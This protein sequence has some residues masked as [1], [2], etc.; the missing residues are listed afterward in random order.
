MTFID[1]LKNY[2]N[3]TAIPACRYG[4]A[5]GVETGKKWLGLTVTHLKELPAYMKND[6]KVAA[7]TVIAANILFFWAA[8]RIAAAFDNRIFRDHTPHADDQIWVKNRGLDIIAGGTVFALN[9]LLSKA[10]QY[11]LSRPVQAALVIN[12]LVLRNVFNIV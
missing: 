10:C 9:V 1:T 11:P 2:T 4:I 5:V 6:V 12:T 3:E 7:G 8:K